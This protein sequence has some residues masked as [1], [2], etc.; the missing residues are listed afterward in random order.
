MG[1][2]YRVPDDLKNLELMISGLAQ[3]VAGAG[4]FTPPGLVEELSEEV[5]QEAA[6]VRSRL[7]SAGRNEDIRKLRRHVLNTARFMD[8]RLYNKLFT[9]FIDSIL[10]K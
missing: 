1:L 3:H 10:P 2:F 6:R 5:S 4:T 7:N 9:P 8:N